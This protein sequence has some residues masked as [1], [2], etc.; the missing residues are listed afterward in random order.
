M[1]ATKIRKRLL[2][3]LYTNNQTTKA[4]GGQALQCTTGGSVT[5]KG[6]EG[7]R[8]GRQGGERWEAGRQGGERWAALTSHVS[9]V[10]ACVCVCV[11]VCAGVCGCA[12]VCVR[13]CAAGGDIWPLDNLLMLVFVACPSA[14]T[15]LRK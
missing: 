2:A 9:G 13:V 5:Q 3:K 4:R 7:G 11:R 6:K 12:C 1:P 14:H 8:G 10:C 15:H